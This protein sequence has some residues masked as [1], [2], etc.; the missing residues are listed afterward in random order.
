MGCRTALTITGLGVLAVVLAPGSLALAQRTLTLDEA[1]ELAR[2][3][4]RDLRAAR[5]RLEQSATGIAQARAALLPQVTAQGKYTHNY[6]EVALD[7]GAELGQIV[8]G[9]GETIKS[10]SGNA[11]LNDAI[12]Q[13]EQRLSAEYGAPI[14]VQKGDQLNAALNVTV[15]LVVP[16]A[17]PALAA[18]QQAHRA[19]AANLSV[20]IA[21][22][23]FSVAETYYAAAGADELL[24]A[25][26]NAVAVAQLTLRN[27][28]VRFRAGTAT[29]VEVM[30]AEVALVRAAQ[31][32]TEAEDGQAQVYRALGTLLGTREPLRARSADRAANVPAPPAE[33]IETALQL[34]P[35]LAVQRH[36]VEAARLAATASGW[37]WAPTLSAFGNL[38]AQN[39]RGFSG[40][41][42]S[43]AVGLQ[44]D[45]TIY[46]GG[47]RDAQRLKAW[48]QQREY[49]A[50]LEQLRDTVADEVVNARRAVAT[51]R[52]AL[53]SAQRS[54]DLSRETLRLVRAQYEAGRGTQ[55]DLLQAQDSLVAADV[56]VAQARFSIALADLQLQRSSGTFPRT[57]SAP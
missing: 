17:Y 46:D 19:D 26:R 39:Y 28:Q 2:A 3:H 21:A 29:S 50:R 16:S 33:L 38:Q 8:L 40:D 52:R 45:W 24:L 1:L 4:N 25:R 42:Y 23:L 49:E 36:S 11:A 30:R 34:R 44:L 47:L 18:A 9:L 56:A 14:V 31:A 22:V 13:Y 43:W 53:H 54:S 6:K 41:R 5:A 27:A 15:P 57:R 12:T 55:L 51:K 37:R 10:A 20:T 48:A 7:L 32:E 35:E